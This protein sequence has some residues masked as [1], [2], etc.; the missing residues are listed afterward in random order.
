MNKNRRL[1]F[2]IERLSERYSVEVLNIDGEQRNSKWFNID[3]L[4]DPYKKGAIAGE[5][6]LRLY[7]CVN[8]NFFEKTIGYEKSEHYI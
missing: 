6:L 8:G 4:I 1:V 7:Y 5:R 2:F 3:Q